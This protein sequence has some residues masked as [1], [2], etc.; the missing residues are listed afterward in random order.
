MVEESA[1]FQDIITVTG[2]YLLAAKNELA[3]ATPVYCPDILCC[4][5]PH[6]AAL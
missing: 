6:L 3:A 4:L 2:W 1:L 5:L